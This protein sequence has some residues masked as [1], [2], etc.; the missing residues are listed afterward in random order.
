V[1]AYRLDVP[2]AHSQLLAIG[3]QHACLSMPTF[4]ALSFGIQQTK[5]FMDLQ[6]SRA[7]YMMQPMH[8]SREWACGLAL[9]KKKYWLIHLIQVCGSILPDICF[10]KTKHCKYTL[11]QLIMQ[12]RWSSSTPYISS[13]R[14]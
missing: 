11:F 5:P 4:L 8:S 12:S 14:Q 3:R 7:F 6:L 2:L 1:N 9:E 10:N 13:R